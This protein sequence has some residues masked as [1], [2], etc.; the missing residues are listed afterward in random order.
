MRFCLALGLLTS[1]SMACGDPAARDELLDGSEDDLQYAMNDDEE[2]GEAP[3]APT[4]EK[5]VDAFTNAPAFASAPIAKSAVQSHLDKAVGT[6]PGKSTKCLACHTGSPGPRFAFGGTAF[7]DMQG[8]QPAADVEIRVVDASGVAVS[9]HTDADGNFW[10]KAQAALASPGYAG[11]RSATG[12]KLMKLKLKTA[13][14]F[15]CNSCHA[16]QPIVAP[17]GM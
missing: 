10:A 6:T 1:F 17:M 15:D 12:A 4:P 7:A 2:L 9:V 16:D 13:E 5:K 11:D 14:S 3:P 8:T